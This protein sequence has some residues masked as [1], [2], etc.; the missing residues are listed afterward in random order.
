M[1]LIIRKGGIMTKI[2]G[3]AG[4]KHDADKL[5]W[6]LMDLAIR[7]ELEAASELIRNGKKDLK[8][9]DLEAVVMDMLVLK[10]YVLAAALVMVMKDVAL[11]HVAY[12]Y[13]KGSE[14]YGPEDW[15]SVRPVTRYLSAALRH[16]KDGVN[17]ED[18]GC[19]HWDHFVWNMIALRW[20]EKHG[21][22]IK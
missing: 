13:M 10:S 14:K 2:T 21:E 15:K 1:I 22:V 5:Q 12:I 9:L 11:E 4:V 17:T 20:F 6:G 8:G 16:M 18:F 19:R 3:E 7:Q